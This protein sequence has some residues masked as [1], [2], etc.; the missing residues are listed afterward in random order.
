MLITL[1]VGKIYYRGFKIND[2]LCVLKFPL[3]TANTWK[4]PI[5]YMLR[6]IKFSI[7]E[8][9]LCVNTKKFFGVKNM[10]LKNLTTVATEITEK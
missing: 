2:F 5:T 1:S 9:V 3:V 4:R 10:K 6:P 8:V 7:S